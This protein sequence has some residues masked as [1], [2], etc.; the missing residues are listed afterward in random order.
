MALKI[1]V[2]YGGKSTEREVSLKSGEAVFQGL[3]AKGY[4]VVK[5]DVAEQDFIDQIKNENINLAFL[6]L[7]GKYGEDGT[8]QGLLEILGIPYTG[9]GVLASA[10]AMNKV[11]TKKLLQVDNIP[12]P[13]FCTYTREDISKLGMEQV[14][15]EIIDRLS[16]PVV[17]KAPTQG[18]TIGISFVKTK[19]EL[20]KALEESFKFDRLVMAEKFITGTEVTVTVLG[21]ENP[22]VLPQIEI[23]SATGVYDYHAKYTVGM[24]EHII[25]PRLPDKYLEITADLAL[26]THQTL[27]CRGLSRV[28]LI[29]TKNGNVYVLEANTLPGMTETSLVPDAARAAGIEFPDLVSTLVELAL[30]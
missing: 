20:P 21:N 5:I 30:E 22:R 8:I 28:D 24:S 17:I 12:T 13:D 14:S 9:S 1:G 19:D 11:T 7:H 4:R 27:G 26:R 15:N 16:L 18:S 3:K 29:V 10:V 25:P 6:A 23:V 2:L